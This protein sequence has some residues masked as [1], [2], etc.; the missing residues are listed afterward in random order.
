MQPSIKNKLAQWI[1]EILI[2]PFF[3]M[4]VV[5]IFL[6]TS[7]GS[8][9]D[10]I[11]WWFILVIVPAYLPIAYIM[12]LFKKGK[13]SNKHLPIR[14]ERTRPYI[15][16]ILCILVTIFLLKITS[17]PAILII[18]MY[19]Y[20]VNAIF[21]LLINFTWKVSAHAVGVAC[22]LMVLF[23]SQGVFMLPLF[24]IL[25][26]VGW[27]RL[28]LGAHTFWEVFIGSLGGLVLSYVLVYYYFLF[29][30]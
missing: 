26:V 24:L 29:G 14:S 23:F 3:L 12:H 15:V 11:L 27:A 2:P 25:P 5:T 30:G 6:L 16:T 21:L 8:L 17:A 1:S 13:V 20:L 7:T 10:K 4:F 18:L 28:K 19:A 22:P 9:T